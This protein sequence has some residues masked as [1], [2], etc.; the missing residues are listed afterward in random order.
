MT[1]FIPSLRTRTV[2]L[3]AL[4]AF[5]TFFVEAAPTE[6]SIPRPEALQP[7]PTLALGC[8]DEPS[9]EG[10]L[11]SSSGSTTAVTR[12]TTGNVFGYISNVVDDW[13]CTNAFRYDG[14]AWRR[15]DAGGDGNFDWGNLINSTSVACNW[16]IGSTDYLKGNSTT[17]CPDSDAEYALPIFMQ[18]TSTAGD[19]LEAVW[20]NDTNHDSAGDFMFIHSDCTSYYGGESIRFNQPWGGSEVSNRPGTNC[21]P[22][23]IDS[24][25]T[26]QS[27]VVDATAPSLAFDFPS[28]GGPAAYGS[29]FAGVQFDA[30][31]AVAGFDA[32][33]TWSLQRQ[34]ATWNGTTCG[35]FANDGSATTGTTNASNQVA[36]SPSDRR[37]ASSGPYVARPGSAR[38]TMA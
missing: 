18:N 10:R 13:S 6:L 29:T 1:R 28:A 14:L 2:L 25:N 34:K 36:T 37:R 27:V 33:H 12:S 23:V 24:T 17:D 21:D 8:A 31:D 3:A 26:N 11:T 30:T 7:Q 15:D 22:T 38:S 35:T 16:G 4:F 32:T 20:H 19:L 9:F 5:T